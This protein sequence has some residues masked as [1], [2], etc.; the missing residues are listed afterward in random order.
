M[1]NTTCKNCGIAIT[2]EDVAGKWVPLVGG[3][4][5]RCASY[6]PTPV[7]TTEFVNSA[8]KTVRESYSTAMAANAVDSSGRV[9]TRI[10]SS[11]SRTTTGGPYDAPVERTELQELRHAV[12]RL[13]RACELLYE[14]VDTLAQ[15]EIGK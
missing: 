10:Q 7:L 4:R 3:V 9:T 2:W 6:F 13:S 8:G 5:H 12:Q 1:A 11:P 14:A 15:R